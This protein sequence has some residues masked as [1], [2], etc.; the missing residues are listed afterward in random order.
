[1]GYNSV[2]IGVQHT[3]N[4]ILAGVNRRHGVEESIEAIRL[5]KNSGFRA[6]NISNGGIYSASSLYFFLDWR[7]IFFR[8]FS[9]FF[10]SYALRK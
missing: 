4:E 5:L 3:D 8:G 9:R 2:Q 10:G 1:M 6:S 7:M